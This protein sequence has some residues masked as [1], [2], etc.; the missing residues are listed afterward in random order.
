MCLGLFFRGT[1]DPSEMTTS[2][3][4]GPSDLVLVNSHFPGLKNSVCLLHH[5]NG[6][7]QLSVHNTRTGYTLDPHMDT[8]AV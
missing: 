7:N 4:L 6:R 8:P 1:P 2:Y 5:A 3:F